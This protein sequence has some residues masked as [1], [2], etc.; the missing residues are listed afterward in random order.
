MKQITLYNPFLLFKLNDT[1]LLEMLFK[2]KLTSSAWGARKTFIPFPAR[3]PL[4]SVYHR[5]AEWIPP[6]FE[7][8]LLRLKCTF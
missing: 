7:Q 2:S 6:I 5:Q 4:K 1:I 3:K 8:L